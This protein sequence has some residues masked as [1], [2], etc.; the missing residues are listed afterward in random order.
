MRNTNSNTLLER[1][2]YFE[3]LHPH[4]EVKRGV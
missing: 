3:T 2:G 1:Y 4:N